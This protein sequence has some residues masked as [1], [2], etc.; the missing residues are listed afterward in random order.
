MKAK[1][2]AMRKAEAHAIKSNHSLGR[3]THNGQTAT[4]QCT[5]AHPLP[6][7]ATHHGKKRVKRPVH[8][9]GMVVV[10][11]SDRTRPPIDT[12]PQFLGSGVSV[13]RNDDGDMIGISPCGV[14]TPYAVRGQAYHDK[15]SVGK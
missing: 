9:C 12:E 3:W 10:V 7:A 8:Q 5:C 1:K 4:T 6:D 15:R 11:K 2:A 14:G 13:K